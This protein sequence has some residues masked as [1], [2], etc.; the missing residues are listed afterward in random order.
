MGPAVSRKQTARA[1]VIRSFRA[2]GYVRMPNLKKRS[3]AGSQ[4]YK[5]GYE[6]RLVADDRAQVKQ[7]QAALRVLGIQPGRVFPKHSKI[8]VPI[9]GREAVEY[10]RG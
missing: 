4:V 5:K 10:F 3:K 7:L 9:Y 1:L 8:I 2:N 6:V